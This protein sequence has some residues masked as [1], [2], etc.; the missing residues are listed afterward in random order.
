MEKRDCFAGSLDAA[1]RQRLTRA[2]ASAE[3]IARLQARQCPPPP[4]QPTPSV[5]PRGVPATPSVAPRMMPATL[6]V[7]AGSAGSL[8]VESGDGGGAATVISWLS[9]D[10]A[11]AIVRDGVVRAVREGTAYILAQVAGQPAPLAATVIV[12]P[13]TRSA[14]PTVVADGPATGAAA[15]AL[16]P[17]WP[18]DESTE[19]DVLGREGF[20]PVTPEV[21]PNEPD[22]P[23]TSCRAIMRTPLTAGGEANLPLLLRGTTAY[24]IRASC[25][26]DCID[27]D[28]ALEG[29]NL[30]R[31]TE[32]RMAAAAEPELRATTRTGGWHRLTV[33][34]PGCRSARCR[35]AIR[36]YEARAATQSARPAGA[37]PEAAS[38]RPAAVRAEPAPSR[39]EPAGEG[40]RLL[41]VATSR[42][43]SLA[44]LLEAAAGGREGAMSALHDI[45]SPSVESRRVAFLTQLNGMQRAEARVE[46]VRE[47]G[48]EG[49]FAVSIRLRWRGRFGGESTLAR[50]S[51]DAS[52]DGLA[53]E[54]RAP[55]APDD[56]LVD[57]AT[58]RSVFDPEFMLIPE[59][60]FEMG[61]RS[62]G[63]ADER[64]QHRVTV[65]AFLM[66]RTE[67]TQAQWQLVMG[68]QPSR[69]TTCG[70]DCPVEQVNWEDVHEFL[71]RL[72]A[73]D[74]G[75]AY[76]LP[77][78]AEWEY[79]ARAGTSGDYGGSG[80][81]G[82]MGWYDENSGGRTQP[83]GRKQ[84]NA[85]GLY[86][87]HGNVWEWVDGWYGRYDGRPQTN[88]SGRASGTSR[89]QRGGSWIG[90]AKNARSANRSSTAP[91]I[92]VAN[93][94]FRMARVP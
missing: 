76:R 10:T 69:F 35:Y 49:V 16:R 33:F 59:G 37:A 85:W 45:L 86:D 6:S 27:L 13:G 65:S 15:S 18:P 31:V 91:E 2:G 55:G 20:A 5:A 36:V 22:R 54:L 47:V 67:V 73:I 26:E 3:V 87:M 17:A 28:L 40:G 62:T 1:Q 52:R 50:F 58:I 39:A 63:D 90:D 19:R 53:A 81:L 7:P 21:C 89:L 57:A 74:S 60:T 34:M 83:V 78:E 24:V 92:R 51:I 84:P 79:A 38:P 72:N 4:P 64:P 75:R 66:Q 11:V 8:M 43:D 23:A 42:A 70:A 25:D 9:T 44:R 41:G 29:P 61:S 30:G 14:T 32:S 56:E 94:G 48:A 77:T 71:A 82:D 88:P 80:R 46:E 93:G 12:T 68:R